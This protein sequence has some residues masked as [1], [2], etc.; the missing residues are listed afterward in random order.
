MWPVNQKEDKMETKK[1]THRC[2]SIHEDER[3]PTLML[4]RIRSLHPLPV[5][6]CRLPVE[7][8]DDRSP[9]GDGELL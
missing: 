4:Y 7:I 9:P 5:P 1:K 2:Y 3:M 6:G 8:P